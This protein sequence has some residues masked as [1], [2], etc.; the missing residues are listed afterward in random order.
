[1]CRIAVLLSHGGWRVSL[2]LTKRT[3]PVSS[4]RRF[5]EGGDCGC[6]VGGEET[7]DEY[8]CGGLIGCEEPETSAEEEAADDVCLRQGR[9]AEAE[10]GVEP[11]T[12]GALPN[13]FRSLSRNHR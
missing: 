6:S 4:K 3:V 2:I 13:F 9:A 11:G 1:M 12:I 5:F 8:A 7:V 10:A